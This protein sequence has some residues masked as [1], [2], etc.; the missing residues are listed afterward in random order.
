MKL[1]ALF[2]V[3]SVTVSVYAV[4][5]VIKATSVGF[6]YMENQTGVNLDSEESEFL[7]F[8]GIEV[9]I[10]GSKYTQKKMKL[11]NDLD[12]SYMQGDTK[13]IGA[14]LNDPSGQYGDLISTTHNKLW[15]LKYQ[16]GASFLVY[17]NLYLGGQAGIGYREWSRKLSNIQTETYTWAYGIFGL[18]SD[19]MINNNS[20]LSLVFNWQIAQNPEMHSTYHDSVFDLGA[21]DGYCLNLRWN[22]GLS[23]HMGVQFDYVYDKWEIQSS[24][25]IN[26]YYEPHSNTN[27][28]YVKVGFVYKF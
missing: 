14:Y 5:I 7:K 3:I 27:N 11:I 4:E 20:E 25:V 17:K 15:D 9:G 6:D 10:H 12:F 13:Y 28:E 18:R 2:L 8:N 24:N 19:L 21:T 26:N 16:A 1:L 22:Y 23:P